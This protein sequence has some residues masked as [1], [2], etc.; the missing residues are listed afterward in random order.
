ME[1]ILQDCGKLEQIGKSN[2]SVIYKLLNKDGNPNGRV[3]KLVMHQSP[4]IHTKECEHLHN[5]AVILGQCRHPSIIKNQGE[6]MSNVSIKNS[7]FCALQIELADTD[8]FDKI[9]K[10]YPN[11]VEPKYIRAAFLQILRAIDYLHNELEVAHN[12]VKLENIFLFRN[13]A[14]LADF[15]FAKSQNISLNQEQKMK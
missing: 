1:K 7:H 11:P 13:K 8:L 14:K 3:L 2:N 15:G 4:N 10:T 5:E 12:D 6:I 9:A